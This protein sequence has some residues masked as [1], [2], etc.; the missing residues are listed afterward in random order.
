MFQYVPAER[1]IA[2]VES[3]VPTAVFT[4]TSFFYQPVVPDGTRIPYLNDIERTFAPMR[5]G[6][7]YAQS[8]QQFLYLFSY[9]LIFLLCFIQ[10]QT[11]IHKRTLMPCCGEP[12]IFY[13]ALS[14]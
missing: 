11:N 3:S 12:G 13:N 1:L 4:Y 14:F 2:A 7:Q 6:E 8:L 10:R 9:L 5:G